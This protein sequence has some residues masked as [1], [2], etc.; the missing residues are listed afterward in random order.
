MRGTLPLGKSLD[1]GRIARRASLRKLTSCR[2]LT[3]R[4]SFRS[5]LGSQGVPKLVRRRR[6]IV[7][8]RRWV[9]GPNSECFVHFRRFAADQMSEAP[10]DL[11]TFWTISS[12]LNGQVNHPGLI[13]PG[14]AM[15]EKVD[16]SCRKTTS[17]LSP[18]PS[19]L[20]PLLGRV[21]TH[22]LQGPNNHD[23]YKDEK[24][25]FQA[26]RNERGRNEDEFS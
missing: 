12:F 23:S 25:D 19:V 24:R 10:A 2:G 22:G 26:Q 15:W 14:I 20:A 17:D 9:N 1:V 13:V 18:A 6:T 4:F 16:P 3:L 7:R 5:T 21:R 11:L 8:L